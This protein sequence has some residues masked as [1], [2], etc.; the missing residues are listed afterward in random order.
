M[1]VTKLAIITI[2]KKKR[3]LMLLIVIMI[4]K[5]NNDSSYNTNTNKRYSDVS[6]SI[7]TTS[8]N[9]YKQN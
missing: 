7:I 3:K 1:S 5:Y 6:I 2:L 8:S 9:I 4:R